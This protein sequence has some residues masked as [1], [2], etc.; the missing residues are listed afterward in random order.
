[1][2]RRGFVCF[3]MIISM[4][5]SLAPCQLS[6]AASQKVELSKKSITMSKKE[7]YKLKLK[8]AK[9]KKVKWS[10]SSIKIATVKKG[11]V[12]A[13]KK[14]K[15]TVIA[16]YRGKKYKCVVRV[17]ENKK[18]ASTAATASPQ[19]ATTPVIE[20]S[21][22]PV[23][24]PAIETSPKPVTNSAIDKMKLDVNSVSQDTKVITY[25]ITNN[26][27][28]KVCVLLLSLE[29]YNGEKWLPVQRKDNWIRLEAAFILPNEQ[30]VLTEALSED[31]VDVSSGS[32]RLCIQTSCGKLYA[33]FT[34]D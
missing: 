28:E 13:K 16:K 4:L 11:V 31:F 9:S 7:S 22:E 5:I 19:P 8:G 12:K 25:T 32:Y 24:P 1:M 17:K 3:L 6:L 21:P 26:S 20:T 18:P 15:C 2:T 33:E 27:N 14:G 23:T 29:K 34:I 30:A 10:S